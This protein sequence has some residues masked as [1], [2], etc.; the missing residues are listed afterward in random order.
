[1]HMTGVTFPKYLAD[2][3]ITN[4]KEHCVE[5]GKCFL[6]IFNYTVNNR[7][8]ENPPVRLLRIVKITN[9]IGRLFSCWSQSTASTFFGIFPSCEQL[10]PFVGHKL[11]THKHL[12]TVV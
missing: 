4:N 11:C 9:N 5:I 1:M 12:F 6:K 8:R 10:G 3:K 7:G 2:N